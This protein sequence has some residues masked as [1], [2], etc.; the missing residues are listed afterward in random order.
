LLVNNKADIAQCNH[1]NI[2]SSRIIYSKFE[3][4]I[5]LF[6]SDN[7]I[8]SLMYER[9]ISASLWGK[10]IKK[11]LFENEKFKN[12]KK[13]EDF[14]LMYRIILKCNLI[15]VGN[16]YKY[17]YFIRNNSLIHQNFT[18]DNLV[19]LDILHKVKKQLKEKKELHNSINHRIV[20]A[21]FYIM[22]YLEKNNDKYLDA[23]TEI[24][25]LRKS[26]LND[27]QISK[28]AKL[29]LLLSYVNF[30]IPKYSYFIIQRVLKLKYEIFGKKINF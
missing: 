5:K 16:E 23:K 6:D 9:E 2:I 21:C 15:V 20:C 29:S 12:Y 28:K 13:F 4:N 24:L 18:E 25:N 11:E 22:R 27:K 19:I 14:D 3:K 26:V 10:L 1:Y 7:S 17:Y 8:K 30:Q